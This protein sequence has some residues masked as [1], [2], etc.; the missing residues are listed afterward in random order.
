MKPKG[1]AL[2]TGATGGIGSVV[3]QGLA[4]DG[5]R[6]VP[7][8]RDRRRL[9]ELCS[10]ISGHS[11]FV[12]EP[13]PLSVDMADCHRLDEEIRKCTGKYGTVDVLVNSAAVFLSGSLELPVEKYREMVETNLVAQYA[14]LKTVVHIMKNQGSGYIFNIASRAGKYGFP[15]GG[16]YGSTKAG[17]IGLSDSLY[18][19]LA[20]LGIRVVSLCPGWVNTDMAKVSG[21]PLEDREMIQAEDILKTIRYLLD[22]SEQVCVREIV[23]EMSRSLV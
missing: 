3:A 9:Q 20:P 1:L 11:E 15:G 4:R 22:L 16:S 17:L 5:Y 12:Q 6:V 14:I 8:A 21:T 7:I 23:L 19:E 10:R 18:R 13:V 2:V